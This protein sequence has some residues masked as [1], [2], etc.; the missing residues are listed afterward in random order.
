MR[1]RAIVALALALLVAGGDTASAQ[2]LV[3][4]VVAAVDE[5]PLL[6]SEVRAFERLR[7]VPRAVAV[8]ALVDELLMLREA[9]RLPEANLSL[10]EEQQAIDSLV[11]RWPAAQGEPP[12]AALGS[13]ALR[14][15]LILKY[16]GLRFRAQ[17]RVDDAQL[18]AVWRERSG[19][20]AEG[21]AFEAAQ[22][23]LRAELEEQALS[24][25]I[26]AWVGDLRASAR[27]RYNLA[28][29]DASR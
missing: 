23:G 21:A 16:V 8:E 11:E 9:S 26:E 13:I 22:A 1:S 3:E 24:Q 29:E 12:R 27:V 14:Q 28:A 19:Q 17:V 15:A 10:Q 25:R 2:I 18:R 5:Q 7:G 4:H 6:L 20:P